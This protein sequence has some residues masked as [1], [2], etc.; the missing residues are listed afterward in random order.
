MAVGDGRISFPD[1][2][3]ALE[4]QGVEPQMFGQ[5][6]HMGFH[7]RTMY[8]GAPKPRNASLGKVLVAT[9]RPRDTGDGDIVHARGM[10]H[11]ALKHDIRAAF[12]TTRIV[13]HIDIHAEDPAGFIQSGLEPG[14]ARMPFDAESAILLAVEH[15]LDGFADLVDRNEKRPGK[16]IGKMLLPPES[17][18]CGGL[19]D[20]HIPI[21]AVDQTGYRLAYIERALAADIDN[22]LVPLFH[23]RGGIGLQMD[24]LLPARVYLILE[25]LGGSGKHPVDVPLADSEITKE[26]V[27][28]DKSTTLAGKSLLD[29]DGRGLFIILDGDQL[30]TGRRAPPDQVQPED[31]WFLRYSGHPPP[32]STGS[33]S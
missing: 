17:A 13:H 23:Y 33:P 8:C 18:P 6:A 31:R 25:H 4:F 24:M 21:R 10:E 20:D 9:A 29:S 1:E 15:H 32:R 26:I 14:T 12:I 3:T 22:K 28:A 19:P 2:I 27:L 30:Q 5:M 11:P 16:H 7:R